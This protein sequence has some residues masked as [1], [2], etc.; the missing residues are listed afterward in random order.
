MIVYGAPN[1]KTPFAERIAKFY[2]LRNGGAFS[3]LTACSRGY[4]YFDS[5]EFPSGMGILVKSF[6]EVADEINAAISYTEFVLGEPT[7]VGE[8]EVKFSSHDPAYKRWWHGDG[9]SYAIL[10]EHTQRQKDFNASYRQ[11][12]MWRPLW[13][14]LSEEPIVID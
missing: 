13:R 9:W 3:L 1:G 12:Y 2:G 6:R 11:D 14:G 5:L 8:Y 7:I 10:E 4:I